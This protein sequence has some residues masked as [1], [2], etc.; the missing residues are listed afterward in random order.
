MFLDDR[1]FDASVEDY[2]LGVVVPIKDDNEIIGILKANVNIIGPL[3]DVV[4]EFALRHTASYRLSA[5][6][7]WSSQ[8]KVS[9]LFPSR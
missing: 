1:G 4:H 6:V 7:D 9:P 8:S 2:V 3:S 5:R